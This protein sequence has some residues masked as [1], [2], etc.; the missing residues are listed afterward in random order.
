MILANNKRVTRNYQLHERFEAGL[1]LR[2]WEVK[3]IL[4]GQAQLLDS[5]VRIRRGEA[6]LVDC[7]ITPQ[8]NVR[9]PDGADER[10]PR[11]LLLRG[12]ELRKLIGKFK[13]TGMTIVVLDLHRKAGHIKA[14]IALAR[15]VKKH[16]RRER[17]KERDQRRGRGW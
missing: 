17:L 10:Q 1:V 12:V 5:H 14:N 6:W 9:L 4:A 16:D 15:G 2:G 13:Q 7:H 11:K 8:A 3:G